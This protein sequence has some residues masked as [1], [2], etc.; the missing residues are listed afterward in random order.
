ML[1]SWG[2]ENVR[3]SERLAEYVC[4]YEYGGKFIYKISI[5]S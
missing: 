2:T 1:T 3:H 5:S 4:A